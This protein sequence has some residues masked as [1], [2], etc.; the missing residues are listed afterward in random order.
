MDLGRWRTKGVYS[1]VLRQRDDHAWFGDFMNGADAF[2]SDTEGAAHNVEEAVY[3][4]VSGMNNGRWEDCYNQ[5]ARSCS[6]GV[7]IGIGRVISSGV[8]VD[9]CVPVLDRFLIKIAVQE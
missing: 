1:L 5:V 8:C 4:G 3:Y 2:G 7:L 9:K 6:S